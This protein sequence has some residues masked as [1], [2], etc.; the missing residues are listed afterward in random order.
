MGAFFTATGAPAA[1][2]AVTALLG[3]VALAIAA[4]PVVRVGHA[5]G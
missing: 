5:A 1:V 4:S 2:F 3:V